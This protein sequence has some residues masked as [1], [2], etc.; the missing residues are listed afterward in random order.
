MLEEFGVPRDKIHVVYP[1]VDPHRFH[2]RID[3]SDIRRRFAPNGEILI[4]SVGRLQRRKGHDLA[5]G[6][7]ARL[8]RQFP[9][10]RYVIAGDGE[11]RERLEALVAWHGL[12]D[13]V[14]FAGALADEDLPRYYAACDV[15]LLPNRLDGRDVEGFGI[16]FLEAA[17]C[18]R[19]VVAGNTGGVPEAV[20]HGVS[21]LLVSGTEVGELSAV[22]ATLARSSALRRRLGE[23]GRARVLANFTWNRSAAALGG[24]QTCLVGQ[25]RLARR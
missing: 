22:L 4:L 16:V 12:G 20:E 25:A 7:M 13:H 21:G 19:P 24:V 8:A 9:T 10:L 23:A 11:E 3:G 14:H 18:A 1:G 6:A 5:I 2:P 17:A 15:F